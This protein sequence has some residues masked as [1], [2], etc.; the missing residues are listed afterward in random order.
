MQ[1]VPEF[2]AC[3]DGFRVKTASIR[4]DHMDMCKF[5]SAND[6]GYKRSAW[7]ISDFVT[8]ATIGK[9]PLYLPVRDPSAEMVVTKRPVTSKQ[10][11]RE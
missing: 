7:Y 2:S 8:D 10:G 6:D 9:A 5:D 1:I 11:A 3:F 4:A